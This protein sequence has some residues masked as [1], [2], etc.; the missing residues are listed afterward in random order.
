R[1]EYIHGGAQGRWEEITDTGAEIVL[2]RGTPRPGDNVAD[3]LAD[4]KSSTEC[5]ADTHQ[6]ADTNPLK[7]QHLPEGA[8]YIDMLEQVCPEGMTSDS[9]QCPAVVGNVVVWYDGSHLTNQYV[10]TMTPIVEA[11][12]REHA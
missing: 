11:K 10:A 6:I 2:M 4:G 12:L 3:C 9:D 1:A 8:H 5:G 7:E